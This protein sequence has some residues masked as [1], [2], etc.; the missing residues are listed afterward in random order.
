MPEPDEC[1]EYCDQWLGGM[2]V[3]RDTRETWKKTVSLPKHKSARVCNRKVVYTDLNDMCWDCK[4]FS[5]EEDVMGP[6][7]ASLPVET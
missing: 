4:G 6:E 7:D 5:R 1:Y 2:T 3:A